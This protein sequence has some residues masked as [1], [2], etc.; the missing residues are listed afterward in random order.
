M[1]QELHS[2]KLEAYTTPMYPPIP[3]WIK[4]DIPR[5]T[6]QRPP[7]VDPAKLVPALLQTRREAT[8]ALR[9]HLERAKATGSLPALLHD[10]A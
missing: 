1:V 5:K 8:I 4:G 7:P 10:I 9:Q 2:S 6:N 3:R